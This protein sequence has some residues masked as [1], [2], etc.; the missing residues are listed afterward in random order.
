MVKIEP[1]TKLGEKLQ[2]ELNDSDT[3]PV[4][5]VEVRQKLIERS[6]EMRM[7]VPLRQQPA[8]R[9][10]ICDAIGAVRDRQQ[11]C[12]AEVDRLDGEMPQML[13]EPRPPCGSHPIAGLQHCPQPRSGATAYQ[14]KMATVLTGHQFEDDVRLPVLTH[15]ENGPFIGPLH[16]RVSRR[17]RRRHAT[18]QPAAPRAY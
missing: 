13:V 2:L 3:R 12:R 6:V 11:C 17:K 14:P 18:R 4:G 1:E 8:K 5:I 7:R 9:R 15:S 10:Q 16:K